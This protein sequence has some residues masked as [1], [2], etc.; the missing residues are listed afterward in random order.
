[1][2]WQA[3]GGYFDGIEREGRRTHRRSDGRVR[4]DLRKADSIVSKMEHWAF[5]HVP[6]Q[7]RLRSVVR[8]FAGDAGI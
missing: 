8:S 2:R 5:E 4:G 1:M 6:N 3:V 7:W